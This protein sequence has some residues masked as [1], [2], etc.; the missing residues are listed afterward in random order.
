MTT[1]VRFD[2]DRATHLA[3]ITIDRPQ[4]RNAVNGEM[5]A[6]IEAAVDEIEADDALWV[7]IVTGTSEVFCAGGDLREVAAGSSAMRTKRGGFAGLVRRERRTPLIAAVEGIAVGG[8][9]EIVLA[10]DLAVAGA[11]ARFGIPEVKRSVLAAA[12]GLFRL[13]R[14]IPPRIAMEWAL[15]GDF[16]SAER[17]YELGLLNDVVPDGTALDAA[18]ALAARITVN[19]PLAVQLSRSVMLE[20]TSLPED[21]AWDVNREAMREIGRTN[22]FREGLAAF[23]EK[24]PPEWTA[25]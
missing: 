12:G 19:A 14:T 18:R 3:V 17:A 10:A 22:D 8:G 21:Q 15:T 2:A 25:T 6:A 13:G 5:A 20:A 1:H 4:A 7:T 16:A 9:L 24:R 23:A 11:G